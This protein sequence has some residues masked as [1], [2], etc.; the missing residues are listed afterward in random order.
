MTTT[1]AKSGSAAS[2]RSTAMGD[3]RTCEHRW[4]PDN[5]CDDCGAQLEEVVASDAYARGR[6]EALEEAARMLEDNA[7]QNEDRCRQYAVD[8]YTLA[9]RS[10]EAVGM[11]RYADASRIRAMVKR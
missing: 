11:S 3:T 8:G 7:R 4:S 5:S 6:A 2:R 1:D 10:H 9:A